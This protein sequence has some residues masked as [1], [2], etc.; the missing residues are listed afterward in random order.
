[1]ITSNIEKKVLIEKLVKNNAI[2]VEQAYLLLDEQQKDF[3]PVYPAVTHTSIIPLPST[4]IFTGSYVPTV[5][6]TTIPTVGHTTTG[7]ANTSSTAMP[8]G[9]AISNLITYN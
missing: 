8:L 2:S 7:L 4:F 9:V 5:R 6:C 1:M 3:T